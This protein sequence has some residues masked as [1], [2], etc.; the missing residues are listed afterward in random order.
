MIDNSK[1]KILPVAEPLIDKNEL[2][3]VH[4]C[5]ESGWVS[6]TGKFIDLFEELCASFTGTKYGISTANGTVALHL[7]LMAFDIK[8]GD[9]VIVPSLTFIA[10]ANAVTYTGATP[11]FVDSEADTWNI[12]PAQIEAAI[13]SKTKA[14]IPVHLY[15]HPA[16]MDPILEIAKKHSMSL[17]FS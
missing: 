4:E 12:D 7:A 9:E 8:K 5:I 2:A 10:T 15:G 14:I 6:S 3:Y 13:T 17:I 1:R 16:N 11:V